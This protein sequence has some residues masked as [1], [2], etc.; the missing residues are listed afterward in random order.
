MALT[1]LTVLMP[2]LLL[3]V[4]TRWTSDYDAL[5]IA[6]VDSDLRIA[7]Q[8][9][10]R[11]MTTT[12]DELTGV[13]ESAEFA[14]VL[15]DNGQALTSYL[16]EKR[17]ALAL[18]FLYYLPEAE[19]I[20]APSR[21]P[22][23]V[24]GLNGEPET[25]IDIFTGTE[26]AAFP[27]QLDARARIPLI[28][29]EAAVPTDRTVE[30]RGMVVHSAAPVRQ[31]GQ[32]GVL[33]GGILLNRNLQFIDT[34]NA[35]VYLN[36]VTGGERQ[37]TATLFLED[38]RVSTNVRL[39][40]DVRALGTRVSAVVRQAVLGE[41]QTWLARAF[42]VNDWY[43]SGYLPLTDSFGERV[44]MLYVGFLE[45]PF[46]A[47]KR[48]AIL[49]M[50]AAF[51]GVLLL[52]VPLFLTLARGIFAPL[53]RITRTMQRVGAGD[54]S[55]RY[56][57]VGARDEI[58]Q[59][60]GH[61][62]DLLGQVQDRDARLRAWGNELNQRVEARTA[63]LREANAKLEETYRQLVMNEKL[64]SI[65][66]I[67]AG[68]AHE[69]NNPVAVIQGNVDVIRETLGDKADQVKTELDLVDRQVARIDA[70]VGKLLQFARPGE[71]HGY[72]DRV[73]LA[74]LVEDCLLLVEH[75][76]SK[77]AITVETHLEDAPEVQADPGEMQQIIINLIM[78]ALQAM[79]QDGRLILSLHAE[80]RNGQ[81][82]ACLRVRDSGPGLPEGMADEVFDPFFTTKQGE[83]TGLGLSISQTLVQRAG[84][85]ITASNAEGGGA[86]FRVWLP[87]A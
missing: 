18:D 51:A 4:M 67:T 31:N 43:I 28:E 53:E 9:L 81:N 80:T 55:A 71:Y 87:A 26:L 14:R 76:L 35:L 85:L 39:F 22:V 38:V 16:A 47:E 37:G 12:G 83:G 72:E 64:A 84:G 30:D 54:L 24:S 25:A 29:T 49:W 69:I 65:G 66:E 7:E 8:Y 56:G 62:D 75:V 33:V 2:L 19:A 15:D 41:G 46:T 79:G 77:S 32:Q 60:A 3:L 6:N 21:W 58:G 20:G 50:L 59:V 17:E 23:I 82:G 11:I 5:L 61:L 13:A 34:I 48:K 45:A 42:V 86:V 63:E 68:V 44:G 57:D 70:M 27:G 1:P 36:A 73:S 40:E 78:N 74:P 10:A 52:S